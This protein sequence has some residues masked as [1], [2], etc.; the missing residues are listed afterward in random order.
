VPS[1]L[2]NAAV[3]TA[4]LGLPIPLVFG[5]QAGRTAATIRVGRGGVQ[6][7]NGISPEALLVVEGDV[8]PLLQLA[9]GSLVR[10]IGTLRV[11]RG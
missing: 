9:T 10:E 4:L 6:L 11:K 8:E 1:Y 7:A 2:A 5:I 3:R